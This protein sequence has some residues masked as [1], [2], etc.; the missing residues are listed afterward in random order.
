[1][2]AEDA[3][4]LTK[5]GAIVK[6]L[7]VSKDAFT[8]ATK[9]TQ[10]AVE[11]LLL[12]ITMELRTRDSPYHRRIVLG[13]KGKSLR[14]GGKGTRT[15]ERRPKPCPPDLAGRQWLTNRQKYICWPQNT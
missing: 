2:S 11:T 8:N 10:A 9:K 5:S 1:M 13:D 14:T 15:D 7:A 6:V 4:V 12:T 3:L